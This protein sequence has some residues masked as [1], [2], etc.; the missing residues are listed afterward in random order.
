MKKTVRKSIATI[1]L[2]IVLSFALVFSAFAGSFEHLADELFDLGLF[3]G[4]DS[5]F[6]LDR[7]PN[8]GEALVM[9]IRLLGMEEEALAGEYAHPFTDVPN[10][11]MPYV[12][13]AYEK[14]LTTGVAESSFGFR[15]LCT[16]QMYAAFVLRAL[17]YNEEAGDFTYSGALEFGKSKGIIDDFLADGTFTRNEMV[18]V[19]HLALAAAPKDGEFGSLLEKL[20]SGGAVTEAAAAPVLSRFALYEEFMAVGS[21][22]EDESGFELRFVMDIDMGPLGAGTVTMD[23]SM[24]IDDQDVAAA[25][26]IDA[27]IAGEELA[28]QI[29]V[30]DGF[31]YIND[32]SDKIK[33]DAGLADIESIIS[34]TDMN[35]LAF[36][37]SYLF[38]EIT[39]ST[40]GSYT[41]YT[42]TLADSFMEIAMGIAAGMLDSAGLDTSD[43]L[44]LEGFSMHI[45]YMKYYADADGALK[46]MTMSMSISMDMG[47]LG[48]LAITVDADVEVVA[49]GD[50]VEVTLP[51]DL[52]EYVML[53][54]G[55]P[56]DPDAPDEA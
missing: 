53:D 31:V 10:F 12:G 7:A 8:R 4:T 25:I 38:K 22:L 40:E 48:E 21:E 30:A 19:S 55:A 39:K 27:A 18:A 14:G 41:V 24:A 54:P 6:E 44:D 15:S 50:A 13:F 17:G 56:Q 28:I 5:G 11:F 42:A 20:V 29:F 1:A 2:S 34:M 45:P 51:D 52:D 32:G 46:R 43:I 26:I 16:A 33:I 37:P 9:L 35:A 47:I 36:N 49:V 3:K 23:L